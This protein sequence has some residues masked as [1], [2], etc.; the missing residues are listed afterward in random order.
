MPAVE[1]ASGKKKRPEWTI[2]IL[3][4]LIVHI[5]IVFLL[6]MLIQGEQLL[7][8]NLQPESSRA[9]KRQQAWCE[10]ASAVLNVFASS[11]RSHH[12]DFLC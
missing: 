6:I 1:G 10:R 12:L 5:L 11:S 3:F 7:F 2:L 9:R 8:P 4:I